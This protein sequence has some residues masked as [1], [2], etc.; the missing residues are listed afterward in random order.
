[1]PAVDLLHERVLPVYQRGGIALERVR[2]DNGRVLRPPQTTGFCERFHR[3]LKDEFFSVQ[4]RKKF[5][6][7]LG[8]LQEDLDVDVRRY[9]EE[10]ATRAT[11]RR[12]GRRG[13]PSR[14]GWRW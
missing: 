12:G 7:S 9:Q 6:G 10:R 11:A 8:E 2:T 3:T 14:M 1:M 13:R 5:S 4:L